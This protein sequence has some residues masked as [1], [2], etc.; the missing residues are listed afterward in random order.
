MAASLSLLQYVKCFLFEYNVYIFC[1]S[2][3]I[4]KME[5]DTYQ[6]LLDFDSA[7]RH[8]LGDVLL[9]SN[10]EEPH[11]VTVDTLNSPTTENVLKETSTHIKD[12]GPFWN[13][14]ESLGITRDPEKIIRNE[15][16]IKSGDIHRK[17]ALKREL[18][19]E[20]IM[21]DFAH[22]EEQFELLR[23]QPPEKVARVAN[24]RVFSPVI[25]CIPP[26]GQAGLE[27]LS[28]LVCLMEQLSKL[29][30]QNTKLKRRCVYLK[31][32]QLLLRLQNKH[33]LNQ[34]VR[35]DS[36]ARIRP[37]GTMASLKSPKQKKGYIS[38]SSDGE[39]LPAM[40]PRNKMKLAQRS[41][42][43]GSINVIDLEKPVGKTEK[44]KE[45]KRLESVFS[46]SVLTSKWER[47]KKVFS[48]KPETPTKAEPTTIT[49]EQLVR[50][51]SRQSS[52][53]VRHTSRHHHH[54]HHHRTLT[55]SK[56]YD[57]GALLPFVGEDLYFEYNLDRTNDFTPQSPISI[58]S[59]DTPIPSVVTEPYE[60]TPTADS[61][62]EL[63]AQ[64]SSMG[65]S[66][67]SEESESRVHTYA[68]RPGSDDDHL[69]HTQYLSVVNHMRR[70]Q[71]SPALSM[72]EEAMHHDQLTRELSAP[73]PR[74]S[75][76]SSFRSNKA[77]APNPCST[78][79]P[80]PPA[81]EEHTRPRDKVRSTRSA[82]G[83]VKDIIHTRKD[84]LKRRNR[85]SHSAG[86]ALPDGSISDGEYF[87]KR[88]YTDDDNWDLETSAP[89]SSSPKRRIRPRGSTMAYSQ[90]TSPERGRQPS[91]IGQDSGT[92]FKPSTPATPMDVPGLSGR[93]YSLY[94]WV[95]ARKTYLQCISS[96][97]MSLLH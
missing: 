43:V 79:E 68:T 78:P 70:R 75:R 17:A 96:G 34:P 32:T 33:L 9:P 10:R 90:P 62:L 26:P 77:D 24:K 83:R 53:S 64:G 15:G 6:D 39:C 55:S 97:F 88:D 7:Y 92:K 65:S 50:A 18:T 85:R 36:R 25:G 23:M 29:H 37:R 35:K 8:Q 82:W 41:L 61:G 11:P 80:A 12:W 27:H 87:L 69:H 84:S 47:V 60:G 45:T 3:Y 38:D 4:A 59:S 76:S 13:E 91:P 71:S 2:P 73:S 58:C 42:S 44:G 63:E 31:D 19:E 52:S 48:G 22:Q 20:E 74:L 81:S 86:D 21:A 28:H 40:E 30:E 66:V 14:D 93:T 95:S 67:L 1:C 16:L 89:Q 56:S 46:R 49:A 57:G 5:G 54:H 51:N 72:Q 94:W